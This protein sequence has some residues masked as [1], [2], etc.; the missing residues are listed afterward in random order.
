MA[1]AVGGLYGRVATAEN[2]KYIFRSGGSARQR[3]CCVYVVLDGSCL[4]AHGYSCGLLV[5]YIQK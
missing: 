4:E 1:V 2:T 3:T 5:L